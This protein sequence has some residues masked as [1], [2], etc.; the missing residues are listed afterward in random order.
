[1][2][3]VAVEKVAGLDVLVQDVVVVCHLQGHYHAG[4][5]RLQAVGVAGHH[6]GRQLAAGIEGLQL[7]FAQLTLR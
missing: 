4:G 6:A 2:A 5:S 3:F 7:V 1:M